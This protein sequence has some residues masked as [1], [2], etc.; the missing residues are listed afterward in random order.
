MSIAKRVAYL[1]GLAEGLGI[2]EDTKEEKVLNVIIDIL[3][4]IALELEDLQEDVEALDDDIS[5]LCEDIEELE[6]MILDEDDEDLDDMEEDDHPLFFEVRCPS[7]KN[8]I[9]IDEDVLALGAIDCPSCGEK[10]EFD[11]DDSGDE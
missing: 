6:D 8:E 7:C 1:K 11:T 4:D 3:E 9:T 2:G 10:L 5:E